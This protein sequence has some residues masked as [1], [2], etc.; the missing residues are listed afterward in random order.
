MAGAYTLG[1]HAV[2]FLV[3]LHRFSYTSLEL[4]E[5]DDLRV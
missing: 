2:L 3:A 1:G 4:L 5:R